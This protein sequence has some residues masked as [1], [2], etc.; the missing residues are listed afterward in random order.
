MIITTYSPSLVLLFVFILLWMIS[1]MRWSSLNRA[2]KFLIPA[3]VLILMVI[4]D[5]LRSVMG[6]YNF[7]KI[8]VFTMHVPFFFIFLFTAKYGVIKTAF[9]IITGMVFT[10]PTIIVSN[11]TKQFISGG[12][13]AL[14]ISNLL[15]YV[16]VLTLVCFVF[17]RRFNYLFKYGEKSLFLKFSIVP[18]LYYIY[19]FAYMNVN[20]ASFNTPSGMLVRYLPTIVVFAFYFLLPD[21][22][23]TMSEKH[24][25]QS[26]QTVLER[27]LASAKEQIAMLNETRTQTAVY[28]HDMRHHL[29][30]IEG[31]IDSG[32]TSRAKEYIKEIR[33]DIDSITLKRFCKNET[34][35]L[36]CSFFLQKSNEEGV[37]FTVGANLENDIPLSE[38]EF[39][40]VISN[41]LENAFRAVSDIESSK[42]WVSLYCG[43]R[44]SKLLIEIKNPYSGDIK[45]NNGLPSSERQHHGYGCRSIYT[46]TSHHRGICTFEPKDGIFTLQII[47]PIERN[48]R[49]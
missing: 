34:L 43:I 42:K 37:E 46:I 28:Q 14:L 38:T 48:I 33:S 36:L 9:M 10:A 24:D 49:T 40:S 26:A 41:G 22:Y 32:N 1:D 45:M 17:K 11:F 27:Q 8:I 23:K 2:Q 21:N 3:L 35:N 18:V 31:Y 16:C 47:I 7:L 6:S 39:C 19:A 15:S 20:F 12:K 44:H 13:E 5:V 30:M 4:N 25:M 29:A